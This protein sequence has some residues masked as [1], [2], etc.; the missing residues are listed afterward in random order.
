MPA[1]AIFLMVE[2]RLFDPRDVTAVECRIATLAETDLPVFAVKKGGLPRR[3]ATCAEIAIDAKV[4]V[5]EA[6]IDFDPARMIVLPSCGGRAR[7]AEKCKAH[8]HDS[9][10]HFLFDTHD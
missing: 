1:D 9:Y 7:D 10:E 8:A 5:G 4:L 6:V 3:D 2:A